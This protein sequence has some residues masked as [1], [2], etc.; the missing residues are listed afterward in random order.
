MDYATSMGGHYQRM[1]AAL[2]G[3][4]TSGLC[5]IYGGSLSGDVCFIKEGHYQWIMLHLWGVTITA[6]VC[7]IKE[8]HYQW[9]TL[10]HGLER[11]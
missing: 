8:G 9:I 11:A 7:C 5:Y 6:Y 4:T 1:Y 3:V 2:R 10:H